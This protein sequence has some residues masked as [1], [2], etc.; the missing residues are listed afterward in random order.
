MNV[1]F[2]LVDVALDVSHDAKS[3]LCAIVDRDSPCPIDK[4]KYPTPLLFDHTT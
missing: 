1:D 3:N 4:R 2:E